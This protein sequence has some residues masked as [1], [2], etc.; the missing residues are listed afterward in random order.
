LQGIEAIIEWQ[1]RMLA[2]SNNECLL[3]LAENRR[4]RRLGPHG[5]IAGGG[6]P[7]PYGDRLLIDA[8]SAGQLPQA[9]LTILYCST[10]RL[11][12]RA[13]IVALARTIPTAQA[14]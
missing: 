7:A 6:A 3:L 9:R 13:L 4:V 1:Q 10:D 8:V 12:L 2:Q 14:I 11:S 5:G